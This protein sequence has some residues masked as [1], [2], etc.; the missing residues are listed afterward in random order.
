VSALGTS[1]FCS[2]LLADVGADTLVR[3]PAADAST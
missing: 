1:R 3:E 2:M